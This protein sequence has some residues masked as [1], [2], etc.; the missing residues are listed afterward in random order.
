MPSDPEG[1][2]VID[3]ALYRGT[4]PGEE[5]II[6][7]T[8]YNTADSIGTVE[9][10]SGMRLQDGWYWETVCTWNPMTYNGNPQYIKPGSVLSVQRHDLSLYITWIDRPVFEYTEGLA[11]L[12]LD[13]N[14][15]SRDFED[16]YLD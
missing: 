13:Y 1:I 7:I 3:R 14:L 10:Q 9:L 5:H 6:Y 11:S 8:L 16:F 4:T 2:C 12:C 15:Q